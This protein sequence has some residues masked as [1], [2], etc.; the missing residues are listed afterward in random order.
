MRAALGGLAITF[1]ALYLSSRIEHAAAVWVIAPVLIVGGVALVIGFLTPFASLGIGL[2]LLGMAFPW[3][4]GPPFAMLAAPLLVL[5]VFVT[6]AG[7]GLLGPND[8]S[9]D[10]R[11]FGRHEI[12][13]PPRP[14][15]S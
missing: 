14:S 2:C 4:P 15:D 3:F 6:A 13:I 12:V 1:G 5:L 10:G 8:F 9:I 11:L 7:I